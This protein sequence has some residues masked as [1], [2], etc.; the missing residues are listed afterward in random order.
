MSWEISNGKGEVY[1]PDMFYADSLQNEQIMPVGIEA[2]NK[3]MIDRLIYPTI[4]NPNL[5][6]N[7]HESLTCDEM[8]TV[9]RIE[10][11]FYE[12]FFESSQSDLSTKDSYYHNLVKKPDSDEQYF[13]FVI[14]NRHT[15]SVD[16]PTFVI[17]PNSIEKLKESFIP[18]EL[19]TRMTLKFNFNQQSLQNVPPGLYDIELQ[20]KNGSVVYKERQYNALKVFASVPKDK[21]YVINV[22]DT[23][24]SLGKDLFFAQKTQKRLQDFVKAVNEVSFKE[25]IVESNSTSTTS[26]Q[27]AFI[28]FNGDLHNG[29]SPANLTPAGVAK[30]YQSE[31][32]AIVSSL[33]ELS[34]PIFL[35]VGNH[36]GYVAT[37]VTPSAIQSSIEF[38]KGIIDGSSFT[39]KT[40]Q[41]IDLAAEYNKSNPELIDRYKNYLDQIKEKP[42]GYHLDL[43]QGSYVRQDTHQSVSEWVKIPESQRNYV[44]YDGFYQWRK[45]YGPLYMSWTFNDNHYVNINSYDLRQHRRTG[46]GMYTVNYGG[47]V[48]PF[49]MAWISRDMSKTENVNKDIILLSHHDPRGGHRG[50]DYPYYFR[51]VDY[52][53]MSESLM[54]YVNGEIVEP[55]LCSSLPDS[56]KNEQMA[57]NCMHDGLQEWMRADMEYDCYENE[58]VVSIDKTSRVCNPEIYKP[59]AGV[60]EKR[61]LRYSGY[62]LIHLISKTTSLQTLILGHTH[63]HSLQILHEGDRIVPAEV[64]LDFATKSNYTTSKSAELVNLLRW[65]KESENVEQMDLARNGLAPLKSDN[66]ILTLNLKKAGHS[67]DQT[68]AGKNRN[69]LIMRM[70]CEADLSDQSFNGTPMLGFSVFGIDK[71]KGQKVAQINEVSYYQNNNAIDVKGN[72]LKAITPAVG[73]ASA[74]YEFVKTLQLRRTKGAS[75]MT[76]KEFEQIGFKLK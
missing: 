58:K 68:L 8:M 52:N 21:Y 39:D 54:N 24:V 28:I 55:K 11:K 12:P 62:E 61:H 46:W 49:Q 31:A 42:G 70:T 75:P 63:Y 29:G 30:T 13:R 60:K 71:T 32:K 5:F 9:L 41:I 10:K 38:A 48:S 14:Y 65:V 17:E 20:I 69:L 4:G 26:Q 37:G 50:K 15:G 44:L 73:E 66:T 57:S 18:L 56:L 1:L 59:K 51:Q 7:C 23:Q 40:K 43:F 53:G 36:D 35:T 67:F 74:D 22:T 27:A 76:L 64:S 34:V 2:D 16:K 19:R 6:V 3:P 33:K 72:P 25:K 47:G 45:T